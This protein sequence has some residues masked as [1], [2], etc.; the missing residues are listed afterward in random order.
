[1]RSLFSLAILLAVAVG[2]SQVNSQRQPALYGQNLEFRLVAMQGKD[3][4]P[5]ELPSMSEGKLPEVAGWKWI[6]WDMQTLENMSPSGVY[7]AKENGM[8]FLLVSDRPEGSMTHTV[9]TW[10]IQSIERRTSVDC[11]CCGLELTLDKEGAH[12][13]ATL[14]EAAAGRY[15]AVIIAGKI[16]KAPAVRT[17]LGG[18]VLLT[19]CTG[20]KS[21]DANGKCLQNTRIERIKKLLME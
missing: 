1:M 18:K 20:Q 14:S 13:L 10:G 4:L 7:V 11:S 16:E 6:P 9:Q 3:A 2:C 19:F 17:A 21:P 5:Q 15:L 8:M 12:Q